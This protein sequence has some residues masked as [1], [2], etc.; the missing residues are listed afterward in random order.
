[1]TRRSSPR[2]FR[3]LA[4]ALLLSFAAPFTPVVATV[5]AAPSASDLESAR[6]AFNEG[7]TLRDK[8][9][10]VGAVKKLSA[11]WALAHTPIIGLELARTL[12]M[13]GELVEAVDV[14]GAVARTDPKGESAN[15][16][17][18]R[19]ESAKLESDVRSRIPSL[20]ITVT[21]VASGLTPKVTVDGT[22]VPWAAIG[23][24]RK[25]D[26]G[27][28]VVE[29]T[30][31]GRVGRAEVE[32]VEKD[33]HAVTVAVPPP[34]EAMLAPPKTPGDSTTTVNAKQL[35]DDATPRS[36]TSPLVYIGVGLAGA[37]LVVG[38]ITGLM[39]LSKSSA[40]K[41]GCPD[42]HCPPGA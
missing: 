23:E 22:E 21:G 19:T 5:H 24:A 26:P 12:V 35:D 11:A 15:A 32:L 36:R 40:V 1:M 9:D 4:I 37:G 17:K 33:E 18:A 39:T 10:L 29:V 16:S 31:E 3:T 30:V 42:G 7:L 34:D 41:D 14:L 20:R 27:K 38:S 8:G 6:T 2:R 28:H 25:V 13:R